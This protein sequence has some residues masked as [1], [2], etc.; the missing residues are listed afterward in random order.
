[1]TGYPIGFVTAEASGELRFMSELEN[2]VSVGVRLG[3]GR[4]R[5]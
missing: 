5:R 1:M 4:R 2:S 3:W